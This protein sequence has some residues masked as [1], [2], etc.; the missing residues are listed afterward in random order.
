MPYVEWNGDW[1]RRQAATIEEAELY[2]FPIKVSDPSK[3]TDICKDRINVPSN[4]DV[5][6]SPWA[7]GGVAPFVL[8][9]AARFAGIRSDAPGE[10]LTGHIDELDFGFFAP[11]TV[12]V[13]GQDRGLFALNPFLYVDN[14]AGVIMGREIFGFPKI[15]GEI[16][17]SPSILEFDLHSL[18]F[19][20]NLPETKATSELLVSLRRWSLLSFFAPWL[21][22]STSEPIEG[23]GVPGTLI[24]LVNEILGAL[25]ATG[26]GAGFTSIRLP[27]L[28]QYRSAEPGND[29][30][31]QRVV[32]AAFQVESISAF[33]VFPKFLFLTSPLKLE[34]F[35]QASVDI[36]DTLGLDPESWIERAFRVVCKLRL[37]GSLLV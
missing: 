6:A 32:Q 8:L 21:G 30:S 19:K 18:A 23:E 27:L 11:V 28:K 7:P 9:T 14:P 10:T 16:G 33:T 37:E 29:A 36:A 2:L 34:F 12:S 35:S 17:W 22:S 25:G 15:Q 3:L 13:K 31:Y 1:S 4:G 5:I 20:T 24:A 26:L